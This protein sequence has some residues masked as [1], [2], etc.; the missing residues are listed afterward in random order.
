MNHYIL[1][2]SNPINTALLRSPVLASNFA[3]R[4]LRWHV[5]SKEEASFANELIQDNLLDPLAVLKKC[6]Q[7]ERKTQDENYHDAKIW[8]ARLS[9]ARTFF[10]DILYVNFL[11]HFKQTGTCLRG[12][13]TVLHEGMF[14]VNHV[15]SLAKDLRLRVLEF[16]HEATE[17]L[18][19]YG[20][21]DTKS[22]KLLIKIIQRTL[23]D[24][25]GSGR[26]KYGMR[27]SLMSHTRRSFNCTA[28]RAYHRAKL[29][30]RATNMSK[31][32]NNDA[33]DAALK[34][35]ERKDGHCGHCFP[36]PE[37]IWLQRV[38]LQYKCMLNDF[39][40]RRP[41]VVFFGNADDD[42]D[43]DDDS[44][45][46]KQCTKRWKER[47][48]ACLQERAVDDLFLFAKHEYAAVRKKAQSA[49]K[50]TIKPR[51][52]LIRPRVLRLVRLSVTFISSCVT[53]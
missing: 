1:E 36:V 26:V 43:D 33:D 28:M 19:K 29:I 25:G 44:R 20:S 39:A 9:Q 2:S 40:F 10:P 18:I 14:D 31:D 45:K 5:S 35:T 50:N 37:S 42:D 38:E 16:T 34:A 46:K 8:I 32:S 52:W 27:S 15:P 53:P 30:D 21:D 11:S 4:E 12:V 13:L 51:T 23:M 41:R 48:E 6:L 49:V 7:D 3:N 24:S 17:Y 47:P 22:S